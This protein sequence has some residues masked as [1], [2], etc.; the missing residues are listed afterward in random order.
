[1]EWMVGLAA[2][3]ATLHFDPSLCE[4]IPMPRSVGPHAPAVRTLPT[5]ESPARVTDPKSRGLCPLW[6]GSHPP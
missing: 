1:M 3:D 5:P 6:K 2:L 4:E